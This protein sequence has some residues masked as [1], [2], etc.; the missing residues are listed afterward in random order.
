MKIR[1]GFVSNSSTASFIIK[2][3]DY[4]PNK[5]G[6]NK[7]TILLTHE[8]IKKLE[9]YGFKR[10]YASYPDQICEDEE[11][12][13]GQNYGYEITCNQD[14]VIIFLLKNRIPFTANEHYEQYSLIYDGSDTFT[15][16]ANFGKLAL[17]SYDKKELRHIKKFEILK[18]QDYLK[19]D[20]GDL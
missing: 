12:K 6:K 8:Q 16:Y 2:Y 17:M 10:T 1:T 7:E 4:L 18:R 5:K 3:R 15:R 14:E 20:Q 19:G 9:D 13:G 11:G